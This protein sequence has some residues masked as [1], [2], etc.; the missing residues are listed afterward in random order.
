MCYTNVLQILDLSGIPLHADERTW[1]DPIVIGGGPCAYNPEPI[2][3]FFDMFYI[4]EG[5][6]VY[7]DL[8]DTYKASRENA[9]I[10]SD[11]RDTLTPLP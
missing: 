5:E 11:G 10:L 8:L 2:A 6:T 9:S 4:G 7:F 1:E 3:P